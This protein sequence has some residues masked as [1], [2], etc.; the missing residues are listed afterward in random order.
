MPH[1]ILTARRLTR[2]SLLYLTNDVAV[3]H[4]QEYI[5][6]IFE[7]QEFCLSFCIFESSPESGLPG[8]FSKLIKWLL[9]PQK[10]RSQVAET[11][12]ACLP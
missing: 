12:G 2:N 3:A 7:M 11:F 10:R 9:T 1:M 4:G 8:E 5:K 6:L